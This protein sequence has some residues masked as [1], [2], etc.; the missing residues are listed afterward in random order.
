MEIY[1]QKTKWK[2]IL[3]FV[4]VII[5]G[6]SSW[7]TGKL[8]EDLSLEERKR[9]ELWAEATQEMINANPESDL[10]VVAFNVIESNESIP[11]II[12]DKNDNIISYRNLDTMK[13]QDS[14]YEKKILE[15]FKNNDNDEF[16]IKIENDTVNTVYYSNSKILDQVYYFPYL[17]LGIILLFIV[18]AYLLFSISRRA[19][20]NH[21]WLGMSK[22]TAHQLGTPISS[23]M[24]WVEILKNDKYNEELTTEVEKDIKRLEKISSRFSK[25]GSKPKLD[26]ENIVTIISDVIS[27]ISPRIS[28]GIN[29]TFEK[30]KS[31]ILAP[32]NEDLCERVI[33]NLCKNG[34]DAIKDIGTISI[35]ISE[36]KKNILID[37]TDSG[38][39]IAK[40][41]FRMIFKPGY[42]TKKR[43]WGLGLSL[44][45]RIIEQYHNGKIFVK[46]S[47]IGIGTTF[48]IILKK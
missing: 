28:K 39:G 12:V 38:K 25:I 41:K 17:Q 20:Q 3:L 40:S 6:L 33:E 37:I 34:A 48:R 10:N 19:E 16:Y 4:A 32:I 9:I 46:N 11:V 5:A 21:I 15:D 1:K 47:K 29:I 43:G 26:V 35:K 44:A 8:V 18:F 2:Y 27:Y 31:T 30:D 23:L 24:A 36:N 13:M 42:T 7:Y 45:K 22:E 14:L